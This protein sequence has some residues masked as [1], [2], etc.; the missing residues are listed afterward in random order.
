MSDYNELKKRALERYFSHLNKPQQQAV[1]RIYGPLLI[2]A[3]AGSGKTTVIIN[4]IANMIHFGNA[5]ASDERMLPPTS[6]ELAF[7]E[8]FAA[9][10]SNDGKR[11]AEVVSVGT[12]KPWSILAITFTNK[13]AGELKDRISL[14]LGSEGE[15]VTACTFHS[16]CA[17]ILRI[18]CAHLG[19]D[20]SF[21]IYDTDDS[22]RVL[23]QLMKE[24][25]VNDKLFPP[26]QV[27][28]YISSRK[29]M[30]SSPQETLDEAKDFQ[31]VT[32]AK[33][34]AAYQER[35][36]SSDAMDFDDLL[37]YTVELFRNNPDVLDHYQNRYKFIMV[38]EYQDTN[39]VQFILV[40][41]LAEKYGNICVVGD[42]D[43]SIYRFRG[44]TIENIMSF[45]RV[46]GCDPDAGVIRLEQNYR[47]TQNILD[48]ANELISHNEGRMGKNLFT[49]Q[50][51]G[52]PVSVYLASDQRVEGEYVADNIEDA[53]ENG[54]H[55]SDHAVL[56]RTNAQSREIETSLRTRNIP[57]VVFGGLRFYDRKEIRDMLAYL[58][59]INNSSDML[60]L[61]RII[62]E[63]KRGIGGT[64]VDKLEQISSD[65]GISPLE[66]MLEADGY[67]P[68]RARAEKLRSVAEMF[69][70]F[71]DMADGVPL[72]ML[73]DEV[74][75]RSGYKTMLESEGDE[76]ADRLRNI[77]E[78]K[79]AMENYVKNSEEPT[80]EGY[81]E[82]ISLFTD[83]DRYDDNTDCVML[84]TI[85]SAK[86]LE[87]PCVFVTGMEE[88]LFPSTFSAESESETEEER[89]LCYVAV[90]R[91]KKKLHLI[92]AESRLL[93]GSIRRNRPSRFLNEMP[94]SAIEHK[95]DPSIGRMFASGFGGSSSSSASTLDEMLKRRQEDISDSGIPEFS[96]GDRVHHKIFGEGT[97][98][99][100]TNM[101]NDALLEIAFDTRGTK[102]VMAKYAKIKL[103]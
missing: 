13:A 2:L 19:F 9:G 57:Y 97:V 87:F 99:K 20:K 26:K 63:P 59:F 73:L 60:R 34:Y 21:T 22:I 54:G 44:A 103:L 101:A 40:K 81:L 28:G 48:C 38:D 98:L 35:L 61:R 30:L 50:G 86:G 70:Y 89:R 43:Q 102:R 93:Y 10:R 77:E 51:Q 36:R 69:E 76:G 1:F 88:D 95:T 7:L 15:G 49:D 62:N 5:Y 31:A 58:Q 56:Y 91:A 47:S 25:S 32:T 23:K 24:Q 33:L 18:E 65:L 41:M 4:R 46:F 17:R 27:L 82:E 79:S 55:Y 14:M 12:V 84:M 92:R 52:E 78:L 16:L 11:L 6:E 64:T 45:D 67:A 3:G 96:V 71:R 75:S 100:V 80:L 42:D 72:P 74:L 8:D 37:C 39:T 85:H 66:V 68:I 90:T 94:E 29:E 83:L 53:V